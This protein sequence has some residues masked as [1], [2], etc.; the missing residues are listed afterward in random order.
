MTAVMSPAAWW[1]CQRER[2]GHHADGD[3]GENVALPRG[4]QVAIVGRRGQ[5]PRQPC[6]GLADGG[7]GGHAGHARP[8]GGSDASVSS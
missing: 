4:P 6:A 2:Q 7:G 8:T 1:P 3:P 5:Q